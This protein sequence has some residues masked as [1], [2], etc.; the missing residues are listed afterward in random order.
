MRLESALFLVLPVRPAP[1][2]ALGKQLREPAKKTSPSAT[3][4]AD[5]PAAACKVLL[6]DF[7]RLIPKRGG[8][9]VVPAIKESEHRDHADDLDHLFFFGVRLAAASCRCLTP[10][11]D[12]AQTIGRD[13]RDFNRSGKTADRRDVCERFVGH[14]VAA[15]PRPRWGGPPSHPE[16][17]RRPRSFSGACRFR[18]SSIARDGCQGIL[19]RGRMDL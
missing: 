10:Q 8:D 1:R 13:R 12:N 14:R 6:A 17:T 18:T 3:V 15:I 4:L 9:C 11:T 19:R 7:D 16:A 5:F 2:R